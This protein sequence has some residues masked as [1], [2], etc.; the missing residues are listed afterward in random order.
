MVDA[1]ESLA[2]WVEGRVGPDA[3][4]VEVA[5]RD[6]ARE[7]EGRLVLAPTHPF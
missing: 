5:L 1:E 6:E 3:P 2:A 7:L 4:R